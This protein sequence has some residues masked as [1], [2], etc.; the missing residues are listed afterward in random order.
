MWKPFSFVGG[1][2]VTLVG[3][4]PA[5]DS[6]D[7]GLAGQA[8]ECEY[9]YSLAGLA[10]GGI[11]LITGLVSTAIGVSSDSVDWIIKLTGAE[12][13]LA[14]AA[15]GVVFMVVVLLVVWATRFRVNI[16]GKHHFPASATAG[17]SSTAEG[18]PTPRSSTWTAETPSP[19]SIRA[20][21]ASRR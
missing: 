19:S 13:K 1:I 15:P 12:S 6:R 17:T 2:V 3:D 14:G 16:K 18:D 8:V 11:C 9:R 7:P 20:P 5:D 21:T 10:I 4:F